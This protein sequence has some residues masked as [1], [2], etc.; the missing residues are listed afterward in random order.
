[1]YT[2]TSPGEATTAQ[3]V[4]RTFTAD[5]GTVEQV[6]RLTGTTQAE[7]F[8][9]L[10]TPQMRG[11]RSSAGRSGP[12]GS[13]SR[14]GS[15]GSSSRSSGGGG[16]SSSGGSGGS[17]SGGSGGGT[18]ATG[19]AISGG[20]ASTSGSQ[21]DPA[22]VGAAG[23]ASSGGRSGSAMRSAT[24]RSGGAPR[25]ASRASGRTASSSMSG[26][27]STA[28]SLPGGPNGPGSVGSMSG[29]GGGS[30]RGG[31]GGGSEFMMVLQ[32]AAKPGSRVKKGDMIAEFDRQYMLTRLDD[33]KASVDQSESSFKSMLANLDTTKETHQQSI[34]TAKANLDKAKL[35]MRTLPVRS[36][37]DS[38][39]LK[40]VLEEAQARYD[41]LLKEVKFVDTGIA[42]DRKVAELELQQ[43]RLEL[44][45]AEAN[46]D[47]MI[48]KAPIDGLIVMQ[49]TFRGSDF[50]A[51]KVGDQLSPGQNFMQIVDP[52][53]MVISAAV[54]QVDVEKV[55]IGLKAR[56]RFDAFP[57]LELPGHVYGLGS[58]AKSAR[59]R[60]D[61]VKEMPVSIKL[62]QMDPRVIPDLSVSVDIIL[63]S[64]E[65][66]VVVPREAVMQDEL[67]G[68]NSSEPYALV[69]AANGQWARRKVETGLLNHVRIAI[70]SGVNAGEVVALEKPIQA[71]PDNEK[72]AGREGAA[73]NVQEYAAGRARVTQKRRA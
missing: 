12:S 51:I 40:L 20:V 60:P 39:R 15:P 1:M 34:E 30:S 3:I 56:V 13:F 46:A 50:D 67:P 25:S 43:S 69:R 42:A 28:D 27:G 71:S 59:Y 61:W 41:Q 19:A 17:S 57:G 33:Y 35:D 38:E 16:S 70:K 55:R 58:V 65:A 8:V 21:S 37:M 52:S 66:A 26:L 72:R 68:G 14:G 9:S 62:D 53:S 18:S 73:S 2:R 7:K 29:G 36:A 54:S 49:N 32:D 11:S 22:A 45:R 23:S 4:T 44:K 31:G 5:K 64:Q 47:R 63:D 10:L 48:M 24:S 6:L